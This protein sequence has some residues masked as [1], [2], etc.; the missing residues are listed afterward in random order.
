MK[1]VACMML[2]V[3]SIAVAWDPVRPGALVKHVG[4]VI[5]VDQSVRVLLKFIK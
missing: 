1:Q 5:I 3:V 4:V 2:A